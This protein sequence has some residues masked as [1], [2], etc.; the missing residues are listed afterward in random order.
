MICRGLLPQSLTNLVT[1]RACTFCLSTFEC[2][3]QTTAEVL[4]GSLKQNKQ[5]FKITCL[6][7]GAA[8]DAPPWQV[9]WCTNGNECHI[10]GI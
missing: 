9:A 3:G 1:R 4:A 6:S 10:Y 2:R 7:M 5:K 8:N